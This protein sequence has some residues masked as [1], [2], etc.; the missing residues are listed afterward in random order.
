[1]EAITV[2]VCVYLIVAIAFTILFS[3]KFY[4]KEAIL[5]G[6]CWP[7]ILLDIVINK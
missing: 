1:M 5:I 7:Y 6:L 4:D 3:T 2:L